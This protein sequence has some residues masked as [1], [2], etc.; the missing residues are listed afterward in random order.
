MFVLDRDARRD[1]APGE[2]RCELLVALGVPA[3]L[4]QVHKQWVG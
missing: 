1:E 4:G 2:V 3:Q